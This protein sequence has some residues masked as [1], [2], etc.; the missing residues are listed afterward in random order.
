MPN[1]LASIRGA[2]IIVV[3]VL[4]VLIAHYTGITR[5][6]EHVIQT[7][8]N[9]VGAPVYSQKAQSRSWFSQY[10]C[11]QTIS[12]GELQQRIN[13]LTEENARLNQSLREFEQL[14]E[15]TGYTSSFQQKAI[16]A[17]VIGTVNQP[18]TH[19]LI[20]DKGLS[21]GIKEQYAVIAGKG[22]II[23]KTAS[24]TDTTSHLILLND[25]RSIVA[26]MLLSNAKATGLVKGE[27]GL[28]ILMDTIPSN[29]VIEPA[30]VAVT[31][32]FEN[33]IPGGL[34]IGTVDQVH[35]DDAK[36]F[37]EATISPPIRYDQLSIVSVI[38]PQ[39]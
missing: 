6:I 17:R 21:D 1:R 35:R 27:F 23:G 13:V 15:M 3:V 25:R 2:I 19:A 20:L 28:G 36:L 30:A 37:A 33:G 16:V 24:V 22:I 31:S 26:A 34:V 4:I 18:G 12:G 39:Q 5:P 38:L 8:I 9:T 14:K 32:G 10:M 7:G 29:E 11:S